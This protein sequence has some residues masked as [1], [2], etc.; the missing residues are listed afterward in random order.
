M[1]KLMTEGSVYS[2]PGQQGLIV[3]FQAKEAEVKQLAA[4]TARWESDKKALQ[5]RE[6]E[7][8]VSQ[9]AGSA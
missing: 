7:L 3:V 8:Q 2:G 5:A 4:K 1:V 6:K 9:L